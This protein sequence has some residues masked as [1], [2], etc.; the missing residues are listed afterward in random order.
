[1]MSVSTVSGTPTLQYSQN[2]IWMPWRL[3]LSTTIRLAIEPRTVRL[4]ANG[5]D[6]PSPS[7][8]DSRV[9]AGTACTTGSSNSTAGT[10]LTRFES[11]ADTRLSRSTGRLK[12]HVQPSTPQP[13]TT[14]TWNACTTIN[15]PVNITSRLQSTSR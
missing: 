6:I 3:A 15:S 4:P 12:S 13:A 9:A 14:C 7:Q 1:M 10:L 8:A 5:L 2:E 11:A